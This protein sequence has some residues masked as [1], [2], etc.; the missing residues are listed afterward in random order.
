M[1]GMINNLIPIIVDKTPKLTQNITCGGPAEHRGKSLVSFLLP[2][3]F[4]PVFPNLHAGLLVMSFF[5]TLLVVGIGACMG[6]GK[7]RRRTMRQMFQEKAGRIVHYFRNPGDDDCHL[8][9][10]RSIL[11]DKDYVLL[12]D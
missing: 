6:V 11:D 8:R 2:K 5:A 10:E 12:E 4:L 7:M 9:E 1:K 3:R